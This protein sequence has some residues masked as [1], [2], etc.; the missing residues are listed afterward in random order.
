MKTKMKSLAQ[1]TKE[2]AKLVWKFL[3]HP[4]EFSSV[5]LHWILTAVL[6]LGAILATHLLCQ[7]IGTIDLSRP[8]FSSYF[9]RPTIFLLNLLPIA[10]LFV[11]TYFLTNRAWAAFLFPS[12]LAL[13][14][15]F[16]NYFKIMLRGD[17]FVF[18]DLTLIGEGL[19]IVGN[20]TLK[21]PVWLWIGIAMLII[22]T[23]VF[24]R[25]GRA[26]I[27]KK[28]WWIRLIGVLACIGF[29]AFAWFYWYTDR[30]LYETQMNYEYF[31][32]NRES[33]YRAAHGFF[34]SFLRSIDE[35]FPGEP[36]DYSEEKAQALLG[37]FEDV[38][39]PEN[40]RVN[41]VIT[42]LES[43]ADLSLFEGIN[44][45]DDPYTELHKLQSESYSGTLFADI[46]GGGTVNSERAV[47]TGY[48]YPHSRYRTPVNSYVRYFSQL[49]YTTDGSHPGNDWFYNRLSVNYHMGFD[50][51]LYNENH[52]DKVSDAAHASD[53]EL[54]P[55][56]R[57]IYEE[58]TAKDEP[59]FSFS[60][61][62]QNH[63][64]YNSEEL[65]G[66]EYVSH[67]GLSDEAYY[68][69]NNYLSGIADT[70]KQ[71]AK[72]VDS[73]RDDEEPVVLLFFGDHKAS[74]G[75]A[76]AYY[77]QLG[78]NVG[79]NSPEGAWD[80]YTTPYFIWAND[81]A[82]EI[83]GDNFSGTG[84]TISHAYLMAELFD[85][86]GWTGPAWMQYQRQARETISVFYRDFLYMENGV[87]SAQLSEKGKE[88]YRDYHIVQYYLQN[89]LEDYK[90][91]K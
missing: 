74:L 71:L 32:G 76:N 30:T 90:F 16:V 83:L 41:V 25:Y 14:M 35:A 39:I 53:A 29:G 79:E 55:E 23:V 38:A 12:I 60:V 80:L 31:S 59:Y 54:F 37:Q 81:A 87:L 64:P 5:K 8:R 91:K 75:E 15:V 13:L 51:Y 88:V 78:L 6:L 42:M 46:I 47:M 84:R 27:A 1:W 11:F 56:L 2:R 20:Y 62:F 70:G 40:E 82:K 10:L 85:V 63:T 22:G 45:T 44:F 43:Y 49:G 72:Y 28:L 65:L 89:H 52:Y 69:I 48:L 57:R 26:R 21:I 50:R 4:K 68:T 19:G 66:S 18:E 33:E 3:K 34:W 9:H 67:D 86:C 36:E 73:F 24:V 58:Q 77:T 7:L 61:T 17:P